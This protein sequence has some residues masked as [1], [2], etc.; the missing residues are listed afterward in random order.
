MTPTTIGTQQIRTSTKNLTINGCP[1]FIG[2]YGIGDDA[3]PQGR[4]L[5]R[6]VN[7]GARQI[8]AIFLKR[9]W[10]VI[11]HLLPV[12]FIIG[13]VVRYALQIVRLQIGD[14]R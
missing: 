7:S 3:D 13:R 14:E 5:A 1:D 9:I 8:L 11:D 10:L 12:K 2:K 6:L 4:I